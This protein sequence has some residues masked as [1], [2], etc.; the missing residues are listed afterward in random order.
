MRAQKNGFGIIEVL[1]ASSIMM[2]VIFAM[3][4][5]GRSAL[6]GTTYLHERAQAT[7]LAQEAIEQTRQVRDTNW[8]DD[9]AATSFEQFTGYAGDNTKKWTV[10]YDSTTTPAGFKIALAVTDNSKINIDDLIFTRTL[11]FAPVTDGDIMPAKGSFSNEARAQNA[12]KVT[13]NVEWQSSGQTK[14][15]SMSEILTNWRPN[16]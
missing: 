11:S 14:N 6:R 3:T 16:Y 8:L 2:V 13:V 7:Y 12:V 15:I 1:I 4:A 9:S 5:A 10:A